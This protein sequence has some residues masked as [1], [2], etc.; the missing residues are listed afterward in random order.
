[1]YEKVQVGKHKEKAQSEKDSHSK[2]RDGNKLN[3]QS[4]TYTIK[5]YCKPN[6]QLFSQKVATQLPKLN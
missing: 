1:M 2:N 5:T 4:D 6:G 3:L